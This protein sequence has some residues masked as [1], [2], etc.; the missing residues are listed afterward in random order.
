M[1]FGIDNSGEEFFVH[2]YKAELLISVC[3]FFVY[4]EWCVFFQDSVRI[5]LL[6]FSALLVEYAAPHIHD[7][8]NK[9]V[10]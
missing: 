10:Q 3:H 6:Q 2:A 9:Y 7:A 4:E 1:Y 5:L 8:S